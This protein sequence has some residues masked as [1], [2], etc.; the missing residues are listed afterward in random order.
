M[1]TV[2]HLAAAYKKAELLG[3]RAQGVRERSGG[4]V[5]GPFMR[6]GKKSGGLVILETLEKRDRSKL[7][8][9][10]G[11]LEK[12]KNVDACP[13]ASKGWSKKGYTRG[14]KPG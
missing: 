1:S 11:P 13:R 6:D 5:V 2:W 4:Q 8:S 10:K 12:Y 14:V 3:H 9:S 7:K